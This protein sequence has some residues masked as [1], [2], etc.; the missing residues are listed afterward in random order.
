MLP[1]AVNAA[2]LRGVAVSIVYD[3]ERE[4]WIF[5]KATLQYMGERDVD[6]RNGRLLGTNAI[7]D[8]AFVDRAGEFPGGHN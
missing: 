4:G 3:D 5:D 6:P 7:L 1:D 8:R 2:G